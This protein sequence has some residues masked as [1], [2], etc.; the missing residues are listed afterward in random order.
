MNAQ[1]PV[2]DIMDKENVGPAGRPLR[3]QPFSGLGSVGRKVLGRRDNMLPQESLST[4]KLPPL[5]PRNLGTPG[6]GCKSLATP[7][8]VQVHC[9]ALWIELPPLTALRFSLY[10]SFAMRRFTKWTRLKGR[11]EAQQ[12]RSI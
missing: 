1:T 6:F 4:Q 7:T 9:P 10:F 3:V 5:K 2:Q 11:L 8:S 12:H